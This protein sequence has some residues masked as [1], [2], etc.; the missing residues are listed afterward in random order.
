MSVLTAVNYMKNNTENTQIVKNKEIK[1]LYEHITAIEAVAEDYEKWR[2]S[3]GAEKIAELKKENDMFKLQLGGIHNDDGH[4]E[5]LID[6]LHR[7][8]EENS[9]LKKKYSKMDD[10]MDGNDIFYCEECGMYDELEERGGCMST[11]DGGPIC[12]DCKEDKECQIIAETEDEGGLDVEDYVDKCVDEIFKEI[13][14]ADMMKKDIRALNEKFNKKFKH[15]EVSMEDDKKCKC[16][17]GDDDIYELEL[18]WCKKC[19]EKYPD[20]W[21]D[22]GLK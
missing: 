2:D 20:G 1:N 22:E 6:Q 5:G 14:E 15:I 7:L 17:D 12:Q 8:G 11:N 18:V 21:E 19:Y 4:I 13:D 9:E 10:Y 3:G 16:C